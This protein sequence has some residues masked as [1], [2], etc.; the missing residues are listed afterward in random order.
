M[1]RTSILAAAMAVAAWAPAK[2]ATTSTLYDFCAKSGCIDG[3]GN[4]IT[5]P[6]VSDARGTLYGMTTQGGKSNVGTIFALS[7]DS[8]QGKWSYASLFSFTGTFKYG[9]NPGGPLIVDTKGN[10]Y[11]VARLGGTGGF[12]TGTV[13]ELSPSA[14]RS[15]WSAKLLYVFCPNADS[16]PAGKWPQ[17]GGLIYAGQ[18]SGAPYDGQSPLYGTTDWGGANDKGVLFKLAPQAGSKLWTE[19]VLHDFCAQPSGS[20]CLD[21]GE[22]QY[23]LTMDANGRLFGFAQYGLHDAGLVYQF[24][25]A[26]QGDS[27]TI[28]HQFCSSENCADGAFPKGGL[29]LNAA[30]ELL[31]TTTD[32]GANRRGAI[33]KL[34]P[35]AGASQL[36]VLYAFCPQPDCNDGA[37]PYGT[38][39]MDAKG[40]LYGTTAEGGLHKTDAKGVGGGT[41]FQFKKGTLRRL[42]SFCV[43]SNCA[44][45]EYPQTGLFRDAKGNLFGTTTAGGKHGAGNVFEVTP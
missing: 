33:F 42:Y 39:A 21:G 40:V 44:D 5:S 27:F 26:G 12:G 25:T 7:F 31:G 45:G 16:C 19:T 37:R 8:A 13:F 4:M 34:I 15:K 18:A 35:N 41:V 38:L 24:D 32:G 2:A 9:A 22:P 6:L 3:S 43:Q 23:P 30:G 10:L 20:Q 28:L 1:L 11:G 36:S 29:T 17:Y 14:D